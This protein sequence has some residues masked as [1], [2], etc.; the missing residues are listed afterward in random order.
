MKYPAFFD[1]VRPIQMVDPLSALL[2]TFEE[3]EVVFTYTDVVKAAGHSC[4]TVG[5]AYLMTLKALEAL[6][7]DGGAVRGGIKVAFKEA[8]EEGVAG[9]IANVVSQITGATEKSGF[10]GLG[11]SFSRHSLMEFG[12]EIPSS[13]RF[14]RVDSGACVDLFYDPSAVA[15]DPKQP[16]LMTQLLNGSAT[17]EQ[18]KRF[19]ALWQERV[20]RILLENADNEALISVRRC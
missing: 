4:P 8:A 5:G 9:V 19:A 14:S 18:I 2:G 3:G 12:A 6:Y 1:D 15:A 17:D 10:K 16:E 20:R 13:A 11:G 7:P